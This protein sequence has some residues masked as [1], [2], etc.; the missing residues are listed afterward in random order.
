VELPGRGGFY[1]GNGH[2]ETE[3]TSE[4]QIPI[5]KIFI[6]NGIISSDLLNGI[7]T[8]L[9][10]VLRVYWFKLRGDQQ[11]YSEYEKYSEE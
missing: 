7:V 1:S 5:L 11:W 4:I 6:I 10:R 2:V 9:R 3:S 8:S